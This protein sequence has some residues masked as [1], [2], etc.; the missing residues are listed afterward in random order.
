[1]GPHVEAEHQE[2]G[3]EKQKDGS[4][5]VAVNP[6][7]GPLH[8]VVSDRL[9]VLL[10]RRLQQFED[11]VV[12]QLVPRMQEWWTS[13]QSLQQTIGTF[14][15]IRDTLSRVRAERDKL[16]EKAALS[17]KER[18]LFRTPGAEI[19]E[20]RI[21]ELEE[22]L[23]AKERA[24]NEA[25]TKQ[26]RLSIQIEAL[27]TG[28]PQ[29][30]GG[31][32]SADSQ[33][34]EE[35]LRQTAHQLVCARRDREEALMTAEKAEN[36]AQRLQE[37]LHKTRQSLAAVNSQLEDTSANRTF[38]QI[39][40]EQEIH[41]LE[42]LLAD[43]D[44][45]Y[46]KRL[47]ETES[48]NSSLQAMLTGVQERLQRFEGRFGT[49]GWNGIPITIYGHSQK[50]T[51]I[52][53][54]TAQPN[55]YNINVVVH[56]GPTQTYRLKTNTGH[57][58]S[59]FR[60]RLEQTVGVDL[61]RGRRLLTFFAV[62]PD[63]QPIRDNRGNRTRIGD[64]IPHAQEVHM[65][66]VP[67]HA[68][69]VP[70][71][72]QLEVQEYP[73]ILSR[74]YARQAGTPSFPSDDGN[75]LCKRTAEQQT[76][77]DYPFYSPLCDT[78]EGSPTSQTASTYGEHRKRRRDDSYGASTSGQQSVVPQVVEIVDW[79]VQPDWGTVDEPEVSTNA[80]PEV[81]VAEDGSVSAEGD[82]Q[83]SA[84]NVAESVNPSTE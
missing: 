10:R 22:T 11:L 79:G 64:C 83:R 25:A 17:S 31:G 34:V 38:A 9:R 39:S 51:D 68:H 7:T 74:Y 62:S 84:D 15:D 16:R 3:A 14:H 2:K 81:V 76:N 70:L 57:D 56:S 13:I 50:P 80:A 19:Y 27:R 37:E 33:R 20:R 71:P 69:S 49:D 73:G 67:T 24:L 47:L 77:T 75:S 54:P 35:D 28:V 78:H 45:Y 36:R 63:E 5:P 21:T 30:A 65:Y 66:L 44:A 26:M 82:E 41:R 40:A 48:R 4:G 42:Q 8:P 52:G 18:D 32:S 58:L 43:R 55:L 72:D 6:E 46:T 29:S 23:A 59:Q 53:R 12:R 1:M 61:L 60:Q